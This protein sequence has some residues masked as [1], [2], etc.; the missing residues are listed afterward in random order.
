MGMTGFVDQFPHIRRR[1]AHETQP[2]SVDR[3]DEAQNRRVK[4]LPGKSDSLKKL[5]QLLVDASIDRV[6]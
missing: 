6:P 3:M 4:G 1:L 5:A 2:V